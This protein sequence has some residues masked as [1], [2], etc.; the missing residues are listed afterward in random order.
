MGI[1]ESAVTQGGTYFW[2]DDREVPDMWHVLYDYPKQD[3]AVTF[4]CSFHNEH[5]GEMIQ[6]LGRDKTLEVSSDFCRTYVGEWKPEHHERVTAGRRLAGETRRAAEQLGIP[7]P[8]PSVAPDYVFR[9]G[10]IE[11]SSHM[12]NFFDCIRSREL[13]RCHVDRAFEEAVA[14]IMSV[15]SYRRET[16]VKWDPVREMI[17]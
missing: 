9:R 3:L 13:P 14:F 8:P 1:P 12:Q 6:F 16:K 7:P 17:V 15:E 2:K 4:G 10:E 5:A 11:V